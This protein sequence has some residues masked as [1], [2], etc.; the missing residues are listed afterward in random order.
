MA[1]VKSD[2]LTLKEHVETKRAP[3]DSIEPEAITV[4]AKLLLT[5]FVP[6]HRFWAL[7]KA[8]WVEL[9]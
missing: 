2:F 9:S 7:A 6:A 5:V 1:S 4:G 8:W 3:Q